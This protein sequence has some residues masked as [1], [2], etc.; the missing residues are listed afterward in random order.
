MR[1]RCSSTELPPKCL[2]LAMNLSRNST[3]FCISP[4]PFP[5]VFNNSMEWDGGRFVPSA[6]DSFFMTSLCTKEQKYHPCEVRY[7]PLTYQE[8][9]SSHGVRLVFGFCLTAKYTTHLLSYTHATTEA[10]RFWGC[11]S[12]FAFIIKHILGIECIFW[13]LEISVCKCIW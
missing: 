8:P 9:F 6:L 12:I 11:G 5:R 13:S 2:E 1:S 10:S 7:E 3:Q 4:I